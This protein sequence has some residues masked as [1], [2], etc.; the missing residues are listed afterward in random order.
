MN[1]L[2]K[3]YSEACKPLFKGTKHKYFF[4]QEEYEQRRGKLTILSGCAREIEKKLQKLDK[5]EKSNIKIS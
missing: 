2:D 5:Y 1:H 4:T 3:L